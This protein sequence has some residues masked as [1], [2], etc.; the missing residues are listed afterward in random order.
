MPSIDSKTI[1]EIAYVQIGE[2]VVSNAILQRIIAEKDQK[3]V[4]LMPKPEADPDAAQ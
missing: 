1:M 2:L 4:E 3:I